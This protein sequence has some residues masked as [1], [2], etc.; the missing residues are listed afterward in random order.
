MRHPYRTLASAVVI[1][2]LIGSHPGS[3]TA[4]QPTSHAYAL[5]GIAVDA[6][7]TVMNVPN[8]MVTM[9]EGGRIP[10]EPG[11]TCDNRPDGNSAGNAGFHLEHYF[12]DAK[13]TFDQKVG[14]LRQYMGLK[15]GVQQEAGSAA[16]VSE[17]LAGAEVVYFIVKGECVQDAH[18][19]FTRV[20]YHARLI[21]DTTYADIAIVMYAFSPDAARKHAQ[22][23]IQKIGALNYASVK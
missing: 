23:M 6:T 17:T 14:V 12:A 19:T 7:S 15:Q 8:F 21:R 13:V 10:S 22:E 9:D 1:A 18:P 20:S 4:A 3:V 5:P 16:V 11:A 2:A